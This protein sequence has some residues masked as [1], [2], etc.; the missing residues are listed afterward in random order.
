LAG[1]IADGRFPGA[2]ASTSKES[3]PMTASPATVSADRS[4]F[5]HVLVSGTKV[6]LATAVAVALALAAGRLIAAG[7][8]RDAVTTLIV[9]GG[10]TAAGLLPGR[11]AAPRSAEGVAGAAAI[12]L[13]GT[14]VFMI[15]DIVVFRPI[16]A[17]PWTW[18][19]IGGGSTWWYLPIWW[20][21]GTYLAWMGGL[22]VAGRGPAGLARSAAPVIA[23]ALLIAGLAGVLGFPMGFPV[24]ALAGF[25]VSLTA[26]AL[27]SMA[28]PS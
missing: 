24:T 1:R 7:A 28:R 26:L 9:L 3:H 10:A 25:V 17:Y 4:D 21:L 5:R 13:W 27:L 6:G 12:G 18:D 14:V 15:V 20:M 22:L 11:W 8:A 2:Y 23:G 16:K 19:A